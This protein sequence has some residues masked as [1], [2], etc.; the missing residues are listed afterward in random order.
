MVQSCT[1]RLVQGMTCGRWRRRRRWVCGRQ[2]GQACGA[3]P[4]RL[5]TRGWMQ[6]REAARSEHGAQGGTPIR[7]LRLILLPRRLRGCGPP[8]GSGALAQCVARAA[9]LPALAGWLVRGSGRGRSRVPHH[10][11]TTACRG[12]PTHGRP[13]QPDPHLH[14]PATRRGCS[15]GRQAGCGAWSGSKWGATAN[16]RQRYCVRVVP[17]LLRAG[18]APR[19]CW[20]GCSASS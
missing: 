6:A 12:T 20:R 7:S 8:R 3:A 13:R 16:S 9:R 19:R 18:H 2:A 4:A 17:K 15:K 5:A 10:A 14:A 1:K 11:A